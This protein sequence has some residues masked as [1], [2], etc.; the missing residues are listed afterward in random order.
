[1]SKPRK[2]KFTIVLTGTDELNRKLLE[3][4]SAQAKAAIRKAARPALKPTL[5][6]ARAN[7]PV[8]SGALK[9][10]IKIRSIARSRTRVGARVTTAASDNQFSGK[11]FY[12]A[13]L[14]WGW[15]TGAR[16]RTHAAIARRFERQ[17]RAESR[18]A[19]ALSK[20]GSEFRA[21]Q[22]AYFKREGAYRASKEK[23]STRRQVAAKEYLRRAARSTRS[24]ALKLYAD[25]ILAYIRS[26]ASS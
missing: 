16:K 20:R 12:G 21:R 22:E 8:K 1:M 14:E 15:K 2:K 5:T 18:A 7:A 26:I 6:A 17:L 19:K 24:Q 9:R 4:T 10:S 25:G 11:T 13:F 23:A 3:L